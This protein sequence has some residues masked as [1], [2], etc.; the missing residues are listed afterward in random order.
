MILKYYLHITS[1]KQY[2]RII[3]Y[4]YSPQWKMCV[5]QAVCQIQRG[6]VKRLDELKRRQ[7]C[8]FFPYF[9]T[10]KLLVWNR[11]SSQL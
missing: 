2:V 11:N 5:S 6:Y 1:H 9:N 3:L 10:E 7:T 4:P 8:L